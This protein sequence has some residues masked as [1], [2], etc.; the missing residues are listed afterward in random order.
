MLRG[1]A[2]FSV[3]SRHVSGGGLVCASAIGGQGATALSLTASMPAASPSFVL[4][5][6][7]Q[8]F[9]WSVIR[10]MI[11]AGATML[12]YPLTTSTDPM[13]GFFCTTKEVRL[14]LLA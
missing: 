11:S 5:F 8:G 14:F 2:E 13:S 4:S 7:P 10:R 9:N 3:G 12:A 1:E 6:F